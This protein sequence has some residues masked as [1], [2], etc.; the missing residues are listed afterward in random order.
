MSLSAVILDIAAD[1]LA[2]AARLHQGL[3]LR[4]CTM[5]RPGR[6]KL[7]RG[8]SGGDELGVAAAVAFASEGSGDTRV[9]V[10]RWIGAIPYESGRRLE[11][12]SWTRRPDERPAPHVTEPRWHRYSEVIE[13]DQGLGLVR[14]VAKT[15][16]ASRSGRAFAHRTEPAPGPARLVPLEADE[17][18]SAHVARVRRAKE[19]IRA[20]ISTR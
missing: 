4:S 5:P 8:R 14:V 19:L 9:R 18:Q 1:P 15:R 6:P 20:G 13:V 7:R 3:G 11:R 10:P 16:R 17:S 12:P 2:I